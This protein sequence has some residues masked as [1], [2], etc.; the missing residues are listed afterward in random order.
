MNEELKIALTSDPDFKHWYEA[1]VSY[2]NIDE[3][4]LITDDEFDEL[5]EILKARYLQAQSPIPLF[6]YNCLINGIQQSTGEIKIIDSSNGNIDTSQISLKKIKDSGS[7]TIAEVKKFLTNGTYNQNT[8]ELFIAPKLDGIS[9]KLKFKTENNPLLIQTRGGQDVTKELQN[10]PDIVNLIERFNNNEFNFTILHSE[11]VIDKKVFKTKYSDEYENARNC[12]VGVLKTNPND[13]RFIV[14]TDGIQPVNINF[15]VWKK[16]IPGLNL[17]IYFKTNYKNNL[18]PFQV[19]GMVIGHNL[20][21]D[22]YQIKNNYP[23]NMVALKFKAES[24]QTEI[25]GIEWTIKK[26]GKLTPVFHIKPVTLDGT[27]V[28]KASGYS[29]HTLKSK[30]IGIGSIITIHKSGDIIPTVDKVISRSVE[31]NLP[32]NVDYVENGKHIYTIQNTE[33]QKIQKFTLGL[34]LLQLDG[35]GPVVSEK[36]GR[37]VE[38]NIIK[39]FDTNFKP[40]IKIMLGS[41]SANWSR[42]EQFYNI[43]NIPLDQLIEILQI[44]NCGKTLSKK[45]ADIMVGKVIDTK[46]MNKQLLKDT[47]VTGGKYNLIIK[48]AMSKLKEYG[49]KVIKPI[50]ISEDCFSF[51]MTGNPPGM[52]KQEFINKLKIK[53]PNCIHTSLTKN[54]TYLF[55]DDINSNSGKINKAR[56]YGTTIMSYIEALK[57]NF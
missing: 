41:D 9:L 44:D 1:S 18:Y 30:K 52:T 55:V 29:Y 24:V 32:K 3:E 8:T 56:K 49:I 15:N 50:E 43:K 10:N 51:E 40:D 39:L 27:T 13:L 5:T 37:L 20:N 46:G 16:L 38:Y 4:T 21:P 11:L 34:K 23:L 14:C 22:E 54:T 7:K 6:I 25:I 12:I 31:W 33:E 53:S 36:I 2:Y 19:D 57:H 26:S 17:E 47:C 42:F 35:I 48:E 28:T 45:F